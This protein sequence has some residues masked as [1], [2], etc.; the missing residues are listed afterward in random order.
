MPE[1]PSYLDK[2]YNEI[3]QYGDRLKA[4]FGGSG[5]LPKIAENWMQSYR[6]AGTT[7]SAYDLEAEK[8]RLKLQQVKEEDMA[9]RDA[10]ILSEGALEEAQA[11]REGIGER[12]QY[13]EKR[14]GE[15]AA[16][17]VEIM[18]R[19]AQAD[20]Y[21][22]YL[23]ENREV[24][25]NPEYAAP[26]REEF[27]SYGPPVRV[28][29]GGYEVISRGTG[30][31]FTPSSVAEMAAG[32]PGQAA[33]RQQQA[34]ERPQRPMTIREQIEMM[35]FAGDRYE[36]KRKVI[37]RS[38]QKKINEAYAYADAVYN[39]VGTVEGG[40]FIEH[41]LKQIDANYIVPKPIEETED[42][43]SAKEAIVKGKHADRLFM[44]AEMKGILEAAKNEKT[45]DGKIALLEPT[46]GKLLQSIAAG[47]DAMQ[48]AEA[49]RII[50]ELTSIVQ[51]PGESLELI[52]RR[53]FFGAF[54]KDPDAFI[55]KASK[56][57]N[58]TLPA[59]NERTAF[60]QDNLGSAF[61]KLGV[62]YVT[63]VGVKNQGLDMTKLQQIRTG[64]QNASPM[65]SQT[66]PA[67][68]RPASKG[69]Q[70]VP[71]M[72]FGTAVPSSMSYGS[73]PPQVQ[74]NKPMALGF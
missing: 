37:E 46:M 10:G 34:P 16:Y 58:A 44:L 61:K 4:T 63:P 35:P 50:S 54:S 3:G 26:T 67:A 71:G 11:I 23:Q 52:G 20:P 30:A 43:Q 36:A 7:P 5:G 14:T 45:K 59:V 21:A 48:P 42:F 25:K 13:A 38:K 60:Y 2:L 1:N 18:K 69:P 47:A 22:Q 9:Q 68:D 70:I 31:A 53:G 33:A 32:A 65:F 51:A 62:G 12:L 66:N 6:Q 55:K 57:L 49:Q 64:T 15:P 27:E 29:T 28:G 24:L 8:N 73:T 41:T 40:R 19:Q 17:A 74:G 72:R 56:I 39:G